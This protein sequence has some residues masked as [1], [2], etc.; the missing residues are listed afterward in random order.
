MVREDLV[1]QRDCG[2]VLPVNTERT[3]AATS[4]GHGDHARMDVFHRSLMACVVV[5][6]L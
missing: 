2:E 5:A 6:G 3:A 1:G 4:T